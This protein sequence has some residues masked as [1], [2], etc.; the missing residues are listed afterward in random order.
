MFFEVQ[1]SIIYN[2]AVKAQRYTQ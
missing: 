1:L 2:G